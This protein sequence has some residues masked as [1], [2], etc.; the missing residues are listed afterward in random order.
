M[1]SSSTISASSSRTTRAPPCSTPRASNMTSTTRKAFSLAA[2]EQLASPS[3]TRPNH[4]PG[5][6]I[7][8]RASSASTFPVLLP[9]SSSVES[10]PEFTTPD[11]TQ[12]SAHPLRFHAFSPLTLPT[13]KRPK[14]KPAYARML[15]AAT[16]AK[17]DFLREAN[18]RKPRDSSSASDSDPSGCLPST[19]I[20]GHRASSVTTIGSTAD[21]GLTSDAAP[22]DPVKLMAV[23]TSN[24]AFL[25]YA[26][27]LAQSAV[28][29]I[30]LLTPVFPTPTQH[31]KP[32]LRPYEREIILSEEQGANTDIP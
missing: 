9:R 15:S 7:G 5:Y 6:Y 23:C 14:S 21:K 1:S 3:R 27:R 13:I 32:T 20:V 25:L 29:Y 4:V 8:R 11:Y 16:L 28:V 12:P 19:S 22:P 31:S 17:I 10:I 2:A 24:R 26:Q 30:L 18:E